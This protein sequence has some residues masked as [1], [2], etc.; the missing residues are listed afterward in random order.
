MQLLRMGLRRIDQATEPWAARQRGPVITFFE[1]SAGC[2]GFDQG[3]SCPDFRTR[4][5]SRGVTYCNYI[6]R[7]FGCFDVWV[8]VVDLIALRVD[9]P[10]GMLL[11]QRG[12]V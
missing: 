2:L 3:D 12:K 1:K 9:R 5:S 4:C 8:Y 11:S 10:F 6:R 7:G